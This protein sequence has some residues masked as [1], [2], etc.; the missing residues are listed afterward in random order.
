M[1]HIGRFAFLGADEVNIYF[2]SEVLPTYLDEDWD[3]GIKGYYLGVTDVVTDGD[4]TYAIL[5]SGDVAIIEYTGNATEI[6]LTQLN[7]GKIVNIGGEAFAYT[8]IEKIIL[9]ETLIT[10]A[11]GMLLGYFLNIRAEN[12][13][14]SPDQKLIKRK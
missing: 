8:E 6:D 5:K 11:A 2:A 7:Y 12:L 9:P 4:W 1:E 10:I 3:Y 13:R 14:F